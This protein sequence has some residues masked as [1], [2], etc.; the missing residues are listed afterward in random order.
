MA[1]IDLEA[2][3]MDVIEVPREELLAAL[4]QRCH[5]LLGISADEFIAAVRQGEEIDHPAAVRLAVLA[6]TVIEPD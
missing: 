3:D 6:R 5:E 2:L 4:D 1:V